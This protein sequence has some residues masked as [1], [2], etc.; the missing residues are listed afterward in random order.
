VDGGLKCFGHPV[1]ASGLRMIYEC[2]LQLRG[3]AGVRQLSNPSTALTHNLGGG[4][5]QNV[6][7]VAIFGLH[8]GRGA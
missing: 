4:P 6:C 1:G 5:A 3:K 2:W 8:P 7:S